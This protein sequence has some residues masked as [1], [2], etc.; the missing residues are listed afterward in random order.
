[1]WAATL[2]FAFARPP[3]SVNQPACWPARLL[4]AVIC[5][6]LAPLAL[7]YLLHPH[8]ATSAASHQLLAALLPAVPLKQREPLAAFY[9]DRAM[10]GYPGGAA[11]HASVRGAAPAGA[12]AA[13]F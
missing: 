4:Q 7:L 8:P 1:M 6:Q 9:I 3:N 11:Q 12:E 5:E 2:A 10:E 13:R